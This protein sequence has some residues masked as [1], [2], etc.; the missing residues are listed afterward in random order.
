MKQT[1]VHSLGI[2]H[3]ETF[4]CYIALKALSI[5]KRAVQ[6]ELLTRPRFQGDD[7]QRS[8][9]D[10]GAGVASQG[11]ATDQLINEQLHTAFSTPGSK[12]AAGANSSSTTVSSSSSSSEE[13]PAIPGGQ[14]VKL[15]GGL[16]GQHAH[17]EGQDVSAGA[18]FGL[19]AL[20]AAASGLGA[21]PFFFTGSLSAR[22]G[23]LANAMACG[24]MLA[25]SFDLVHEGEP[26]GA[27][28]VI[29]GVMLGNRAP[30]VI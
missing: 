9:G 26:Y 17:D 25:A 7:V 15:G 11:A 16:S 19:T 14:K 30:S 5:E 23:A 2:T 21:L 8:G 29:L 6:D 1:R 22:W 18:V 10:K 13:G 27:G 28:M 4:H 3:Y 20:M 24:V 12:D